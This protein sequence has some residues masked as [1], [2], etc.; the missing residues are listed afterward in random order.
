MAKI[1]GTCFFKVD[2]QQLSLTGGIEVPMNTNVRDDIVGMAWQ[3]MWITRRPGGHLT[4]RARLSAQNFP[5][6]KITTSDQMTITA[7]LAT[8]WC[9]CFRRHGCTE[10]LIIMPKKARQILNSTAKREGISNGNERY[11]NSF[12]KTG[13]SA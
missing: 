12:K 10:R 3:G 2:G 8:A 9:M 4:L 11:R 13:D 1:A 5:V 7:E 6:D